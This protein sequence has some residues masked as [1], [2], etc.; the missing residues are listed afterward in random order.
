[1]CYVCGRYDLL[2]KVTCSIYIGILV[3]SADVSRLERILTANS[4]AGAKIVQ[5]RN[6]GGAWEEHGRS[7]T[8]S[9]GRLCPRASIARFKDEQKVAEM[10]R[11]FGEEG[12]GEK[13]P[14]QT[15]QYFEKISGVRKLKAVAVPIPT[16]AKWNG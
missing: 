5:G 12:Q 9:I 6:K 7:I 15:Y 1:M 10:Q 13:Q 11:P 14:Y 8:A 4:G 3:I 2:Y 16:G